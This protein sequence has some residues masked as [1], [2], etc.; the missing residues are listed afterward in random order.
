MLAV[1]VPGADALQTVADAG[2]ASLEVIVEL[3]GVA[4]VGPVADHAPFLVVDQGP[5]VEAVQAAGQLVLDHSLPAVVAEA[6]LHLAGGV[7]HF[8]EGVGCVVGVADQHFPGLVGVEALDVGDAFV[9]AD[10]LDLHQ[11][12]GVAQSHQASGV[13]VVEVDAVVV[14][15]TQLAQA[16][17]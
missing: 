2:D 12:E 9:F 1:P 3:V 4:F 16:Q 14:A 7:A 15:V 11:V 8:G 17:V 5:F 6:P 10:Q 13:V